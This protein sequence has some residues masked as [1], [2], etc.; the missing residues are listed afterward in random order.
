MNTTVHFVVTAAIAAPQNR[1]RDGVCASGTL[2]AC[3]SIYWKGGHQDGQISCPFEWDRR[4]W[5]Y[6]ENTS[7]DESKVTCSPK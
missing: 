3:R 4:V 7:G 2:L 5:E 6:E 1:A